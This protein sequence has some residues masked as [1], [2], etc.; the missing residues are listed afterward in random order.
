M[1]NPVLRLFSSL[2]LTVTC[3]LMGCVLV[4][5]GTLAQVHLGLYK[6]QNEFFRSVFV[7]WPPDG[8]GFHIPIFP[9]GYLLG[10]VLLINLLCAH[11]RYYQPGKRK[12]GI[13]LIHSA[14][15]CC[16]SGRCSPISCPGKAPCTC[17]S[18][19]REIIPKPTAPSNWPWSTPPTR[20]PTRSSPSPARCSCAGAK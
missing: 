8:S 14:S 12:I 15:C 17:A 18:A 19:K 3:L 1:L 4:F 2:K 20:T 16:C 7:Y 11:L 6:A 9:G 10:T 13:V 5:W